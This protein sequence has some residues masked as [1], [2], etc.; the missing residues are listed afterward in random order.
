MAN[1][2]A[3]FGLR[4]VRYLDGRPFNGGIN[5][6]TI[7]NALAENIGR[8]S[9]V[10]PT[11]TGRN[12]ALAASGTTASVG[13][14]LG[15]SYRDAEGAQKYRPNWVSATATFNSEGALALVADAPDL[16]FEVQADSDGFV[17]ADVQQFA[18]INVGAPDANG[19]ATTTLD[20]SDITGTADNLKILRLSNKPRNGGLSN[21][22]GAYAIAEV[23][24]AIHVNRGNVQ[25]A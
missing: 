1:P 22:F 7:A 20:G 6:Y 18:G 9:L 4:P 19:N 8:G 5:E 21:A 25:A 13:V 16:V 15:C 2:N 3:P 17:A 23:L 11:G 10:K 24:I 12:I 14:F